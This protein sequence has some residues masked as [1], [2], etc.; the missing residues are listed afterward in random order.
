MP[1][2]AGL[3]LLANVAREA[4]GP[5]ASVDDLEEVRGIGPA[6]LD[7]LRGLVTV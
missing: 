6:K 1:R 3:L 2:R 7:A 5:F 4:T